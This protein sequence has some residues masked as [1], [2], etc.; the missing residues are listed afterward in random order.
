MHTVADVIAGA[1]GIPF[2]HIGDSTAEAIRTAGATRV[3]LLGSRYTMEQPFLVERL[4]V[5]SSAA[6]RSSC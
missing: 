1:V 6:R 4:R 2:L 3:G 5:S